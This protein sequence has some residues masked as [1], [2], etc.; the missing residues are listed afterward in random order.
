MVFTLSSTFARPYLLWP[1]L[2]WLHLKQHVGEALGHE[3]ERESLCD[4]AAQIE[5][6][7]W[8]LL[9]AALHLQLDHA[10]APRKHGALVRAVGCRRRSQQQ[11]R[12]A[13]RGVGYENDDDDVRGGE[14]C[15]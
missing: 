3:T 12:R 5:H 9:E 14:C 2:L 15:V 11:E 8:Q 13:L 6:A 7:A 10:L 1:Y 4:L